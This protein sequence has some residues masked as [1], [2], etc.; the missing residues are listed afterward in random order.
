MSGGRG[1][2]RGRGRGHQNLDPLIQQAIAEQ[3][4]THIEKT[5]SKVLAL[6]GG[7]KDYY[8]MTINLI[9]NL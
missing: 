5:N 3:D 4:Q 1:R 6:V 7:L 2:G 8:H 9:K